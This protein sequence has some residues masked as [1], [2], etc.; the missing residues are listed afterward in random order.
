M[1]AFELFQRQNVMD[2]PVTLIG[3]FFLNSEQAYNESWLE[4]IWAHVVAAD[5]W[6]VFGSLLL[7][8]L[9]FKEDTMMVKVD[10][11]WDP[12]I[13]EFKGSFDVAIPFTR[14]HP[15]VDK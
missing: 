11:V 10:E 1:E 2:L 6:R 3:C 5:Y 7:K 14:K 9:A 13:L 15:A 8:C 4:C 12:Q